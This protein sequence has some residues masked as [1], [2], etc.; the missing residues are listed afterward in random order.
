VKFGFRW[1]ARLATSRSAVEPV[2]FPELDDFLA[3]KPSDFLLA[4]GNPP[5]AL[6]RP[7]RRLHPDDGGQRSVRAHLGLR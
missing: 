5:I 7:V 6:G 2:Y 3:N 4:M 1:A